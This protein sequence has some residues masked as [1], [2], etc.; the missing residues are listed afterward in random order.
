LFVSSEM[1]QSQPITIKIEDINLL[2]DGST[3]TDLGEILTNA[4]GEIQFTQKVTVHGQ[5]HRTVDS[6]PSNIYTNPRNT[7][8]AFADVTKKQGNRII[9]VL[10]TMV[11]DVLRYGIEEL[12]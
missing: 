2:C 3:D 5:S 7:I 10:C 1:S 12:P 9:N 6:T 8:N 4:L 11:R